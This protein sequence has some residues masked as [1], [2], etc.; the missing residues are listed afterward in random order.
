[1]S[2]RPTHEWKQTAKC[3]KCLEA[4]PDRCKK[5]KETIAYE[6]EV[7]KYKNQMAKYG[8]ADSSKI[9]SLKH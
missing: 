1:M 4:N 6:K 2:G 8:K 9:I 7:L 3:E 5:T